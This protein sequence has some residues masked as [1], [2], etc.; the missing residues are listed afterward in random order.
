MSV[1]DQI[2]EGSDTWNNWRKDNAREK[3]DLREVDLSGC[4]L[5]RCNLWGVDLRGADLSGAKMSYSSLSQADLRGADLKFASLFRAKA[6]ETNFDNANLTGATLTQGRFEGASFRDAVLII[7]KL[8]QAR[9]P[10]ADFSRADLRGA[11][12]YSLDLSNFPEERALTGSAPADNEI[13]L[14]QEE[15][16]L[17]HQKLLDK[18][19]IG[20]GARTHRA[21]SP[22]RHDEGASTVVWYATNREPVEVM[23]HSKGFLNKRDTSGLHF[24]FCHVELAKTHRIGKMVDWWK[25][26]IGIDASSFSIVSIEP[27]SKKAFVGELNEHILSNQVGNRDFVLFVHGF[28]TS[29]EDS[30]LRGAQLSMDLKLPNIGVFSWPSAASIGPIGY[31]ADAAT[32]DVCELPLAQLLETLKQ[33]VE[34]DRIHIVCQRRGKNPPL[35]GVK[36]HHRGDVNPVHLMCSR[37]RCCGLSR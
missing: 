29:F 2:K 17:Y 35:A 20:Y 7:S 16:E 21:A 15:S 28:N 19:I 24:G 34:A 11:Q 18:E 1:V 27:K 4:N 22:E 3:I 25:K 10:G 36:I 30:I 37:A 6:A 13:E 26:C 31:A 12:D 23:D 32:I 14:S 9:F 33:E 5:S 8:K